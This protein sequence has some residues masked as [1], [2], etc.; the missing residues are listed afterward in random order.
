MSI[1]DYAIIGVVLVSTL[2]SLVRGF[3]KEVLSLLTWIAAFVIA[4]GFSQPAAAF[5]P[6]AVDIPS[7]RVALAFL[8]LFV[9]VL[10]IGGIINWIISTLV[11]KTGLSGTDRSVGMVF[12]LARGVFIVSVLV[13][14]AELT[15]MPRE[16]WWQSSIFVPQFMI[17]ANWIHALLPPSIAM[18]FHA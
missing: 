7:A 15:A 5:V 8:V 10:I 3:V 11:N 12:G 16:A 4:M 17:V 1:V 14:L 9:A 2:I 6:K 13:L 18:Y